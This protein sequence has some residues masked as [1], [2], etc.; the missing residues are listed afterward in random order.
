MVELLNRYFEF[1][2]TEENRTKNMFI[3]RTTL[4]IFKCLKDIMYNDL[5]RI[6]NL[7]NDTFR[8]NCMLQIAFSLKKTKTNYI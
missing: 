2:K 3:Y 8:F 6:S 5:D 4:Y 7:R 1:L